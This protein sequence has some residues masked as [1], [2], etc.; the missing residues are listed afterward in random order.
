MQ[1]TEVSSK[2]D[3][4]C[5]WRS[6]ST[7]TSLKNETLY[8][9]MRPQ[10]LIGRI[11]QLKIWYWLSKKDIRNL[12]RAD[13]KTLEI[14]KLLSRGGPSKAN[15]ASRI[16]EHIFKKSLETPQQQAGEIRLRAQTVLFLSNRLI[17]FNG[18]LQTD[19][20]FVSKITTIFDR[21]PVL[22][23][24]KFSE[25]EYHAA[26]SE[27]ADFTSYCQKQA[28][29]PLRTKLKDIKGYD[30]LQLVTIE[31]TWKKKH[32]LRH[33]NRMRSVCP[34]ILISNICTCLEKE[35][36]TKEKTL[37]K[38][39]PWGVD[40]KDEKNSLWGLDEKWTLHK[41]EFVDLEHLECGEIISTI[42]K[43]RLYGFRDIEK[44]DLLD[45]LYFWRIIEVTAPDGFDYKKWLRL[46]TSDQ[47]KIELQIIP[48]INTTWGASPVE[49]RAAYLEYL[50]CFKRGS[51]GNTPCEILT[52]SLDN[53][54]SGYKSSLKSPQLPFRC[55]DKY[56]PSKV[57]TNM[58]P[59]L[60]ADLF[61]L[62]SNDESLILSLGEYR[63]TRKTEFYTTWMQ[64][65][66]SVALAATME[67]AATMAQ[68]KNTGDGEKKSDDQVSFSDL[69]P[70]KQ[71]EKL[72]EFRGNI[73]PTGRRCTLLDISHDTLKSVH[74]VPIWLEAYCLRITC[75]FG[76][77]FTIDCWKKNIVKKPKKFVFKPEPVQT[78]IKASND[79]LISGDPFAFQEYDGRANASRKDTLWSPE[80]YE[81]RTLENPNDDA[82]ESLHLLFVNQ[83]HFNLLL[84]KDQYKRFAGSRRGGGGSGGGGGGSGG[85]SRRGG[86]GSGGGS[87][88]GGGGSGGG[89]GG[90]GGG[91]GGG[92]GGSG[93]GSGGGGGG[94]GGG[95]RRGGSGG[96]SKRGGRRGGGGGNRLSEDELIQKAIKES[97]EVEEMRQAEEMRKII[98]SFKNL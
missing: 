10:N 69:T 95:S 45:I 3:G 34:F 53:N 50:F 7:V 44:K 54:S 60:N 19:R 85:G 81:I 79:A 62:M 41:Q 36:Q 83:N 16:I 1:F 76:G 17:S 6:H 47:F 91:S 88:R 77:L 73:L 56:L 4:F 92:G 68:A 58:F 27:T 86:G 96:G 80:Q 75:R 66:I 38:N 84:N 28:K 64:T 32:F 82:G 22:L 25:E 63:N 33:L 78:N 14:A 40:S 11:L 30:I 31:E 39:L 42:L 9:M 52:V 8:G 48:D 18:K 12:E 29:K 26:V 90:G 15:I 21:I 24:Q 65:E 59:D 2:G 97:L 49:K 57:L 51:L 55:K 72:W 46:K 20:D 74:I 23:T 35:R 98:E 43:N 13:E 71:E 89:S 94:S 70:E 37:Q 93:G 87:R 5:G 67:Q 61:T